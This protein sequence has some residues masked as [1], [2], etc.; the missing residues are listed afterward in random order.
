MHQRTKGANPVAKSNQITNARSDLSKEKGIILIVD[1]ERSIR[2]VLQE[3]LNLKG[4]ETH[5][6]SSAEA[7]PEILNQ[8]R[9]DLVITNIRMPGMNGLEFT[10]LIK[11]RYNSDVIIMTG[12]HSYTFN[13]SI[14]IGAGDLLH[15]PVKLKD[16]LNS[17]NKTNHLKN[18]SKTQ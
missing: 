8:L 17:I 15:K 13:E 18:A 11:D 7:G 1:D 3:F 16:L 6:A 2:R 12:Y 10:R 4:L 9:V 5:A 14:R